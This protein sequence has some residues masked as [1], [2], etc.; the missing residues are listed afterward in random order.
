MCKSIF[1]ISEEWFYFISVANGDD[2]FDDDTWHLF[3]S[4]E[5]FVRID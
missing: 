4:Y 1:E 5:G 2:F 3:Q